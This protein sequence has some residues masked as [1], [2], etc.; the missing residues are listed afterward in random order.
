MTN[1][2]YLRRSGDQCTAE[3]VDADTDVPLCSKHLG[4]VMAFLVERKVV[5]A[6]PPSEATQ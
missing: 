3:A 5:T 4:R 1:C 6:R 2:R